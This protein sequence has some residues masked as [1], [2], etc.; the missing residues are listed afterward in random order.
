MK[1]LIPLACALLVTLGQG[2]AEAT[3]ILIDQA[4]MTLDVLVNLRFSGV[5][6]QEFTPTLSSLDIVEVLF[7]GPGGTFPRMFKA[8]SASPS[9]LAAS[10][11]H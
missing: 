5:T 8:T 9:I 4:Q 6:G 2:R 1:R 3:S 7:D 10:R 11:A